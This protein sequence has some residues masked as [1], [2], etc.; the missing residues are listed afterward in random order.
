MLLSV[1]GL[2]RCYPGQN[3]NVLR[4]ASFDLAR[5]ESVALTGD[6]GSGKSTLLHMLAALDRPDGGRIMFDGNDIAG[7]TD[8]AASD[9]RRRRIALVFQQFNLVPAL[10]VAENL[11]LH[12]RLGKRYDP[13]WTKELSDRLGLSDLAERYPEQISGGQQQRVAIGRALA[14]RPDL[15]LADEPTGNLD[16]TASAEV[17]RLMLELVSEAGSALFLVTHSHDIAARCARHL[18]LSGGRVEAAAG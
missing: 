13:D 5:G 17:L 4:G 11:A 15:L 12:A 9:L 16:E 10:T 6:S 3:R 8:K 7:L 18:H 2:T 14:V 1:D